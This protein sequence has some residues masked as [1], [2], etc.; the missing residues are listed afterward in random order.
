MLLPAVRTCGGRKRG[1]GF[2]TKF[3]GPGT[4]PRTAKKEALSQL[5]QPWESA[6]FL[7]FI[8]RRPAAAA[9]RPPRP[10]GPRTIPSARSSAAREHAGGTL[11]F[12]GAALPAEGAPPTQKHRAGPHTRQFQSMPLLRAATG[13]FRFFGLFDE[14]SAAPFP[15]SGDFAPS[16]LR[17][18]LSPFQPPPSPRTAGEMLPRQIV[19]EELFTP[20]CRKAACPCQDNSNMPV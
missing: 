12:Q 8:R 20:G 10:P 9:S 1:C 11:R 17:H 2:R 4:V 18:A 6:S 16:N 5:S 13:S 7:A 3:P 15:V 14:V 19:F